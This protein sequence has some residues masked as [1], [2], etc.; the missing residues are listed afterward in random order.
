MKKIF[1]VVHDFFIVFVVLKGLYAF[2]ESIAGIAILFANK[3]MFVKI[4]AALAREELIEDPNDFIANYFVGLANSFS[5]SFQIFASIYLFI[6]GITKMFLVYNLLKKRLLA[7]PIAITV[8]SLFV[9]YQIYAYIAKPSFGLLA[10]T[11]LDIFVI[12]FTLLEYRNLK[13][14][15]I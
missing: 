11:V 12:I 10:L 15:I 13:K 1:N 14:K 3:A 7:Y 9:V 2:F 5:P 6:H 4:V 8:F